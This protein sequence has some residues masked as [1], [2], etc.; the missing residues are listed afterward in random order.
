MTAPAVDV[1]L[2]QLVDLA[3]DEP[4]TCE[5]ATHLE[6]GHPAPVAT[7]WVRI[8]NPCCGHVVLSASCTPCLDDY[9]DAWEV[10]REH[11]VLLQC[12]PC[13][14]EFPAARIRVEHWPITDPAPGGP[15]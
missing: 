7:H 1:D 10:L 5:S 4:M 12:L 9:L 3:L 8:T 13:S 14:R 15:P 2:E 11:Y 6:A